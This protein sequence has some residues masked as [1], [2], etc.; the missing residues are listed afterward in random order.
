MHSLVMLISLPHYFSDPTV[1]RPV[2]HTLPSELVSGLFGSPE[3]G[4]CS[5]IS[6]TNIC[7]GTS[8]L[9]DGIIP[10]LSG[11][12]QSPVWANQ[13]FTMNRATNNERI[14]VSFEVPG[15]LHNRVELSVFN[16]PQEGISAPRLTVYFGEGLEVLGP[17]DSAGLSM[18]ADKNL[19]TTS[20]EHL[21][22]FCIQFNSGITNKFLNLVFPYQNGSDYVF[23]GEVTFLNGGPQC[24][25]PEIITMPVTL[26]PL[27]TT[28]E[29][30]AVYL[31]IFAITCINCVQYAH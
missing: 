11:V 27:P 30:S 12:P 9:S 16:C 14:I 29:H 3:N 10:A 19:T 5:S 24:G 15:I 7:D 21:L 23:L 1:S 31:V 4:G 25:P 17:Q 26:Q 2:R 28:S 6:E 18:I 8:V 20:C 13:L 22:R